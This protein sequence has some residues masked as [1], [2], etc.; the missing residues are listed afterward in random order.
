[1]RPRISTGGES[2]IRVTFAYQHS[3][4]LSLSININTSIVSFTDIY[5][6]ILLPQ[7]KGMD[8]W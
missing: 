1:M 7:S 6:I 2:P 8:R 3:H 4:L 5:S